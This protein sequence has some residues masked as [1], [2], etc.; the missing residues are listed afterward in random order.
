VTIPIL[1][2]IYAIREKISAECGHDMQKIYEYFQSK[3]ASSKL[4]RARVKAVRPRRSG[5]RV[6]A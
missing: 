1:Q 4:K 5:S 6:A 2:E 3:R